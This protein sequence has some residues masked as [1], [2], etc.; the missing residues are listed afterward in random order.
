MPSG[1]ACGLLLLLGGLAVALAMDSFRWL[2]LQALGAVSPLVTLLA[3]HKT[4]AAVLRTVPICFYTNDLGTHP[5][6]VLPE[7]LLCGLVP[8]A[9]TD[10]S[11]T[12]ICR[13][14]AQSIIGL[15]YSLVPCERCS[16]EAL[17]C[18]LV[19]AAAT[20][21]TPCRFAICRRATSLAPI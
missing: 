5:R 9:I 4:L 2:T 7:S 10:V 15:N 20:D 17:L 11:V 1:T 21:L 13:L 14:R 6:V 12:L 16:C 3:T 18:G 8:A 19:P